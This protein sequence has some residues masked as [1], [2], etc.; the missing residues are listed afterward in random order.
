MK[1]TG[2]IWNKRS[3]G[4]RRRKW[5]RLVKWNNKKDR[6]NGD[7]KKNKRIEKEK[8]KVLEEVEQMRITGEHDEKK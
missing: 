6:K 5:R 4:I 7:I 3:Q 1:K 8:Y 2:R